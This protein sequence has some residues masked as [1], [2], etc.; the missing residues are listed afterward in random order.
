M[1]VQNFREADILKPLKCILLALEDGSPVLYTILF[2]NLGHEI[3]RLS[4][5]IHV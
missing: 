5:D 2:S 3:S 1:D 4:I